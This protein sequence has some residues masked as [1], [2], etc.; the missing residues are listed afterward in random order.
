[1]HGCPIEGPGLV[2][3]TLLD[4]WSPSRSP[5][6]PAWKKTRN[7]FP[8]VDSIPFKANRGKCS[9]VPMKSVR[10][11][12]EDYFPL[13]GSL[14]VVGERLCTSTN[15]RLRQSSIS[16]ARN[17]TLDLRNAPAQI[18]F[19]SC[20]ISHHHLARHGKPRLA[21]REQRPSG[22]PAMPWD[23]CRFFRVALVKQPPCL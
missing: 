21:R 19:S 3:E 22:C 18:V 7:Y 20:C 8:V 6:H 16:Y 10:S 1:M 5:S 13:R 2:V 14:C 17:G 4:L 23:L 15:G 11:V 12:L 9:I